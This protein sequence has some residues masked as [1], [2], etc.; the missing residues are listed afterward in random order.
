MVCRMSTRSDEWAMRVSLWNP[1]LTHVNAYRGRGRPAARWDNRMNEF[2]RAN[3][4]VANWH[5]ACTHPDFPWY[6][7]AFVQ[8][9][10][11]GV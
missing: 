6:E 8:F 11:D 2:A 10:N 4:D 5:E 3:L 9:H 1:A 7:E